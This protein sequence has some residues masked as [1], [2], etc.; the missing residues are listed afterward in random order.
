MDLYNLLTCRPSYI[1]YSQVMQICSTQA[2][3]VASE[4]AASLGCQKRAIQEK[5]LTP[6]PGAVS[7]DDRLM[8][9]LPWAYCANQ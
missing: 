6:G 5:E 9:K 2:S 3:T 1:I 7:K 4:E 8:H